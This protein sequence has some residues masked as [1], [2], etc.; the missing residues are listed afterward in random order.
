MSEKY[1]VPEPNSI[2]GIDLEDH[3]ECERLKFL[4]DFE[5]DILPKILEKILSKVRDIDENG[6][7]YSRVL[8]NHDFD[9]GEERFFKYLIHSKPEYATMPCGELDAQ[10]DKLYLEFVYPQIINKRLRKL[11]SIFKSGLLAVVPEYQKHKTEK[12]PVE[13]IDTEINIDS[14]TYKENILQRG[15]EH[16]YPAN[17]H[18]NIVGRIW[19]IHQ[20]SRREFKENRKPGDTLEIGKGW[21]NGERNSVSIIFD[22]DSY[23]E[24]EGYK[25]FDRGDVPVF[26]KT[27]SPGSP[28]QDT[29][30]A[31]I[32]SPDFSKRPRPTSEWGFITKPRI[33]P[34]E[35][36]GIVLSR[37]KTAK[38]IY[39]D[40]EILLMARNIASTMVSVNLN[41]LDNIVPIYDTFGN[42]LWPKMIPYEKIIKMK[43]KSE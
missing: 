33:A 8:G 28:D 6:V 30:K 43:E 35:F 19:E 9:D 37:R 41:K 22:I 29:K 11:K 15:R 40:E 14:R 38:E 3:Q 12:D 17:V 13:T 32:H 5:K 25:Q 18:F 20:D 42:L 10:R 23:Q 1:N 2:E 7:A 26:S 24:V 27:Y 31:D 36:L 16:H 21:F 39:S 4:A 34:R